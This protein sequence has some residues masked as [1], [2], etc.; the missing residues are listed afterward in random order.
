MVMIEYGT[1][2]TVQTQFFV[3]PNRHHKILFSNMVQINIFHIWST[4][5]LLLFDCSLSSI[6]VLVSAWLDLIFLLSNEISILLYSKVYILLS[7]CTPPDRA[8]MLINRD[9]V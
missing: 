9:I 8:R 5:A 3:D 2:M 4:P 6:L 7:S 1:K